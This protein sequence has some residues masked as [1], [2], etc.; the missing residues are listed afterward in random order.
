MVDQNKKYYCN[1]CLKSSNEPM[2]CDRC[3]NDLWVNSGVEPLF[4]SIFLD[5]QVCQSLESESVPQTS[6]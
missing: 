5:E 2:T 1:V 6:I 3:S 4:N